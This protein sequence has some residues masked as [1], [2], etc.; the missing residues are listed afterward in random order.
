MKNEFVFPN[1]ANYHFSNDQLIFISDFYVAI[2]KLQVQTITQLQRRITSFTTSNSLKFTLRYLS[3]MS[4]LTQLW[5]DTLQCR[6]RNSY[7]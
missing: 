6:M 4:F 7:G 1:L 5:L 2:V 3:A